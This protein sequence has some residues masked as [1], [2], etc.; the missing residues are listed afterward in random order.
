MCCRG[1]GGCGVEKEGTRQSLLISEGVGA[2][3]REGANVSVFRHFINPVVQSTRLRG[4][5]L[6]NTIVEGRR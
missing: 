2:T 1:C 5:C 4:W 6:E 3:T